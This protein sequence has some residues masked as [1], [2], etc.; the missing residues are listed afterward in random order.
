MPKSKGGDSVVGESEWLLHKK[1]FRDYFIW[2]LWSI[3]QIADGIEKINGLVMLVQSKV[4][5]LGEISYGWGLKNIE[6]KN[7]I[8]RKISFENGER[9]KCIDNLFLVMK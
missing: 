9:L 3:V 8:E 2:N 5:N 1:N 4:G 6:R 7:I